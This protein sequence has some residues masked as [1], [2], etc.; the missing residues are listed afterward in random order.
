VHYR[1]L[2]DFYVDLDRGPDAL[3]TCQ[4]ALERFPQDADLQM[5]LAR[6]SVDLGRAGEAIRIY[7]ALLSRRPD[8][9]LVEYKLGTLLADED[10][11][12]RRLLEIVQRLGSDSPSDPLLL[13]GLGW[14]H[15]RAGATARGRELLQAAVNGAP[16]EPA[17]HFHLAAV[18][19]RE[20]KTDLARSEL[21]AA[22]DS[23]R[24]F[25]GRLDAMRLLR[26]SSRRP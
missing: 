16:D 10:A 24:P 3:S 14:M 20:K 11:P 8:L 9:D 23:K 18:Y 19:S 15:Y 22:V 6:I 26:E 13:D 4:Q 7:E 2:A 17:P 1:Q 21:K 25:A 5:A 12:S